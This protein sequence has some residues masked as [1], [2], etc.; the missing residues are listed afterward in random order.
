MA[1]IQNFVDYDGPGIYLL[2]GINNDFVYVGKSK[3]IASRIRQHDSAL[4]S[5]NGQSKYVRQKLS[6]NEIFQ[7]EIL[8]K[9][10]PDRSKFYIKDREAFYVKQY[11]A[12]GDNGLNY[13]SVSS[14]SCSSPLH[15]SMRSLYGGGGDTLMSLRYSMNILMLKVNEYEERM[16]ANTTRHTDYTEKLMGCIERDIASLCSYII[17]DLQPIMTTDT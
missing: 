3:H 12:Y 17:Q 8:E 5:K 10:S 1:Y 7:A 14:G 6:G 9:I 11:D 16:Q 4:R 13:A 15:N 2:K